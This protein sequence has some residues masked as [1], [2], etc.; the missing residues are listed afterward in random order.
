MLFLYITGRSGHTVWN[1]IL[2]GDLIVQNAT[3]P[4][5]FDDDVQPYDFN[6]YRVRCPVRR[7]C[8]KSITEKC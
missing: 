6:V 5:I 1:K 4:I 2:Y 7:H 8:F 3:E